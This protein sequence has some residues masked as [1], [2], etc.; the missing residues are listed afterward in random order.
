MT[1]HSMIVQT[2]R[3]DEDAL[4]NFTPPQPMQG[5]LSVNDASLKNIILYWSVKR[6]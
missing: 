2:R 4:Q 3:D 5:V 6:E 1:L